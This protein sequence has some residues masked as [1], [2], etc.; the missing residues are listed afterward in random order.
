VN[1]PSINQLQLGRLQPKNGGDT[2]QQPPLI[3]AIHRCVMM[4]SLFPN[5]L[6]NRR[7]KA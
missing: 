7:V 5:N 3:K 1:T 2:V 6:L 4:K